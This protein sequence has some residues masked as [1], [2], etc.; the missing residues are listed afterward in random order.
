MNK[1]N[2]KIGFADEQHNVVWGCLNKCAYCYARP[3]ANRF[4]YEQAEKECNYR[5]EHGISTKGMVFSDT[6]DFKPTFFYSQLEKRYKFKST[7]IFMNSMSDIM[8]WKPEWWKLILNQIA[9]FPDIK[10]IFFTKA[11]ELFKFDKYLDGKSNCV[12]IKTVESSKVFGSTLAKYGNYKSGLCIEPMQG[13]FRKLDLEW[14]EADF[15]W[16]IIGAETG[17]RKDKVRVRT[18]W[19]EPFYDLNIPVYMKDSI[20]D[21][22]PADK[23]RQER[24]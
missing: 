16:V 18:E 12:L 22:V 9:K 2:Y 23:F 8:Y 4:G 5:K 24:I 11:K 1:Q 21:I 7:H 19:I 14:F 20:K 6:V 10:F 3:I 17:N 15:D 13:R